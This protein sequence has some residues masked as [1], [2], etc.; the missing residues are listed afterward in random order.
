MADNI[1]VIE[2]EVSTLGL[3]SPSLTEPAETDN[4]V[5]PD[6]FPCLPKTILQTGPGTPCQNPKCGKSIPAGKRK[7]TAH[8][9][10]DCR[11]EHD[12][13][14]VFEKELKRQYDAEESRRTNALNW[15]EKNQQVINW[16][17]DEALA[18]Q[19]TGYKGNFRLLWECAK[20]HFREITF[21][22]NHQKTV[23]EVV[24]NSDARLVNYFGKRG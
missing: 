13:L 16:F 12:G 14:L 18:D 10:D 19:K 21:N 11:R 1:E 5:F 22:N 7:D 6:L 9:N 8:C 17:R 2:K 23:R 15:A 20:R 3:G 4:N 24:Q